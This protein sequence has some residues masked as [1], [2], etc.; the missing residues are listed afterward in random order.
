MHG[1]L[2]GYG[3]INRQNPANN[4]GSMPCKNILPKGT[5]QKMRTLS[6]VNAG[7]TNPVELS[8]SLA[9]E[10]NRYLNI[11]LDPQAFDRH[12]LA[13]PTDLEVDR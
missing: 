1:T 13:P 9:G 5:R 6:S 7:R 3:A 12:F 10:N 2:P 8:Q 11:T 4:A